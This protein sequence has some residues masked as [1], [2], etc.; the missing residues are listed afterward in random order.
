MN[1][2]NRYSALIVMFGMCT[3][4]IVTSDVTVVSSLRKII[5]ETIENKIKEETDYRQM[6]IENRNDTRDTYDRYLHNQEILNSNARLHQL[7]EMLC[8]LR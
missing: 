5:I 8:N 3:R 2:L 7:M 1:I 6:M 4:L